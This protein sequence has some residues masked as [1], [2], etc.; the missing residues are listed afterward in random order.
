[1]KNRDC[2]RGGQGHPGGSGGGSARASDG[3]FEKTLQPAVR[4][5]GTGC[6]EHREQRRERSESA[7]RE[8]ITRQ[9]RR[10]RTEERGTRKVRLAGMTAGK[11]APPR[12]RSGR[13]AHFPSQSH[14]WVTGRLASCVREKNGLGS[15]RR[16]N[17]PVSKMSRM[18]TGKS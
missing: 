8:L 9:P 12:R 1:M 2:H 10:K 14:M 16:E 17:G 18:Q 11:S 7:P 5:R 3:R 6:S 4:A 15:S 13:G